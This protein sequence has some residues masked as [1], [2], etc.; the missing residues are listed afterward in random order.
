MPIVA[1]VEA[2]APRTEWAPK[3]DV[4]TPEASNTDFSH[5]AI[6]LEETGLW[7]FTTAIN[8]FICSPLNGSVLSSYA[9]NVKTGHSL[10]SS[11]NEF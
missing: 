2:D 7:G 4:S 11:G 3:I 5:L 1:A 9:F 6:V 8:S 10:A